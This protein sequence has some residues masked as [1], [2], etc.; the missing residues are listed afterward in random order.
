MEWKKVTRENV[1]FGYLPEER[2][3]YPK[4]KVEDQL[5]YFAELKGMRK[6]KAKE[7]IDYWAKTFRSY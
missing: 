5:L 3:I 1:N 2:G 7:S 4:A 6:D